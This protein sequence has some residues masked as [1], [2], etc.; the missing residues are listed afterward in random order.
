MDNRQD[1]GNDSRA[2]RS[3]DGD[4]EKKEQEED[5]QQVLFVGGG[6]QDNIWDSKGGDDT[7]E[8][9]VLYRSVF[10]F[11]NDNRKYEATLTSAESDIQN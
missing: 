2:S 8:R 5:D 6:V 9:P 7:W 11:G 1:D 10:A 4:D 3:N